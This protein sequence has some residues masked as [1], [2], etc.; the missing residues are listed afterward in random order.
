MSHRAVT[1]VVLLVSL[2]A[3]ALA[4]DPPQVEEGVRLF[5]QGRYDE[6]R[7]ALTPA[8][9]AKPAN[10]TAVF[11]LGRVALVTSDYKEA[12]RWFETAVGLDGGNSAYH[13]WLGRAYGSRA[14]R[15]GKLSQMSLAGKTRTEFERAAALDPENLD[16][17]DG[18]IQYYLA[19]P[20]FMGGSVEKARAQAEEIRKRDRLRGALAF[21]AIAQDQH[22]PAGAEREYRSAA[23]AFPESLSVR[24]AL[25]LFFARGE[26]YDEAFAVFDSIL[27]ARPGEANALYQIGRTGALSGRRLERAEQ[28]LKDYIAAPPRE[29][30]PRPAAAHWRLGMV[31]EKEGRKDLARE[32]YGKALALEPEFA[33]AKKSMAKLK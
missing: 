5:Q 17:R 1:L 15:T 29:N 18:L 24:Y 9:T 32:E 30:A 4:A 20:G 26:R 21:A 28:A 10:P 2:A 13:M 16:A 33:E 3:P 25:G 22:D 27:A 12:E 8:A 14:Q 19:A 23:A 11:Y 7:A 6:A 31:Y